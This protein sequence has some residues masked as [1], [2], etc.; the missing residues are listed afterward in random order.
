MRTPNTIIALT[1]LTGSTLSQTRLVQWEGQVQ[2][3]RLGSRVIDAGDLNGDGVHDLALASIEFENF[4]G[5]VDVYS[6]AD[7]SLLWTDQGGGTNA[8][9][10][11]DLAP[12]GD[13]N[14]DGYDDLIISSPYEGGYGYVRVLSGL[15]TI[16]PLSP[17]YLLV[18]QGP[19]GYVYMGRSVLAP[20]DIN[21]DGWID[22]VCGANEFSS[23]G[24]VY[25]FSGQTGALLWSHVGHDNDNELGVDLAIVDDLDGDGVSEIAAGAPGYSAQTNQAG[26]VR[27][28]SGVDGSELPAYV[29]YGPTANARLGQVLDGSGD[30]D[31]DGRRELVGGAPNH[32]GSAANAEE[33]QVFVVAFDPGSNPCWTVR[34]SQQGGSSQA[35]FG[36][37]ISTAGDADGD[38]VDDLFIGAKRS[39]GTGGFEGVGYLFSGADLTSPAKTIVSEAGGHLYSAA[40]V[41]ITGDLTGDGIGE[42]LIGV[43]YS[44]TT[45][46]D[47]GIAGLWS[48]SAGGYKF[49][50]Q[51]ASN[52]A[53]GGAQIDF[54][55]GTSVNANVFSL[56]ASGAAPSQPGL[57]FYGSAVTAAPFGD[58]FRCVGGQVFRLGPPSTSDA[59]GELSRTVDMNAAP[60][61][62]GPGQISSGS[63]WTFQ[64]WYR[65]PAAGGSGFNLSSAIQ[66]GFSL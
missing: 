24:A 54:S 6:G 64:L 25:A 51:A 32:T 48:G 47:H 52:S 66:V 46:H 20:G 63:S 34:W 19:G 12:A 39:D 21:G 18:L 29:L 65:D 11:H 16:S 31:G 50:C 30:L 45:G 3:Q 13:L 9:F 60:S 55:G 27:I 8:L 53:G 44:D 58:G 42:M 59:N 14:G 36:S 5:R 40:D 57:F 2:D 56:H 1:I 49:V 22:I 28:L 23:K 43:G 17:Q 15:H 61:A 38:G 33:G 35:M 4:T 7:Q 26:L 10:G 41:A 37:G 62:S